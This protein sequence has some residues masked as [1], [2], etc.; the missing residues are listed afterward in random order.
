MN[1]DRWIGV[2]FGC[3]GAGAHLFLASLVGIAYLASPSRDPEVWV[4][5]VLFDLPMM[6]V[7]APMAEHL[8]DAAHH[9]DNS[10]D[11]WLLIAAGTL[12]WYL[13]GWLFGRVTKRMRYGTW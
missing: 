7:F 13:A 11:T 6:P 12:F 3:Y 1:D 10:S 4:F 9:A 5:L 8:T 2:R